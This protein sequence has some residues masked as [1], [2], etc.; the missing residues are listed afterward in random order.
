[1]QTEWTLLKAG[2]KL[3]CCSILSN[4]LPACAPFAILVKHFGDKAAQKGAQ[5]IRP[6]RPCVTDG[7]IG[8]TI[9]GQ[10]HVKVSPKYSFIRPIHPIGPLGVFDFTYQIAG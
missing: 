8:E 5:N 1:M 10:S 4:L 6:T 2:H 7:K 9:R 3:E